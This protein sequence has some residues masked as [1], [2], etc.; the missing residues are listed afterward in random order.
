MS[1][2]VNLAKVRGMCAGV[3]RAIKIVERT[4]ELYKD[5][6]V[7]VYHEVVHNRHVVDDLRNLGA[8]LLNP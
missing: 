4:L 6:K 5:R 2:T 7:Y 3:D 1:F 8:V